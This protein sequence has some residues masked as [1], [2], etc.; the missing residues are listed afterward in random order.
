MYSRFLNRGKAF[1]SLIRI[2][3]N[4]LWREVYLCEDVNYQDCLFPE[5]ALG[6]GC[7]DDEVRGSG[8]AKDQVLDGKSSVKSLGSSLVERANIR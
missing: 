7:V 8:G 5:V 3:L 1:H 4:L 2:R 6:V